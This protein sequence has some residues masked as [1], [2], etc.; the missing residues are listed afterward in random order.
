M[1][2]TTMRLAKGAANADAQST[3]QTAKAGDLRVTAHPADAYNGPSLYEGL[4]PES[5]ALVE[6]DLTARCFA[7]SDAMQ[8]HYGV[9]SSKELSDA[10]GDVVDAAKRLGYTHALSAVPKR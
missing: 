3:T 7:L 9:Q 2:D 5:I 1:T 8:R 10:F 6:S 4:E